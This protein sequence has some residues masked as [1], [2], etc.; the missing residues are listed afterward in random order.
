[1]FTLLVGLDQLCHF[2]VRSH[3][4]DQHDVTL[5][6]EHSVG[7]VN[8]IPSRDKHAAYR[9]GLL[10]DPALDVI[11]VGQFGKTGACV[12]QLAVVKLIVVEQ[13]CRVRRGNLGPFLRITPPTSG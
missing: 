6:Q 9:L 4:L 8:V 10:V 2:R 12:Y 7:T 3:R 1:M 13:N 11:D 5:A